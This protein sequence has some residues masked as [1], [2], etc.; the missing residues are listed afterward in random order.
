MFKTDK[1]LKRLYLFRL[2]N[3][4]NLSHPY[5]IGY[6]EN[7]KQGVPYEWTEVNSR[8][9]EGFWG[10]KEMV[11]KITEMLNNDSENEILINKEIMYYEEKFEDKTWWFKMTPTEKW[12]EFNAYQYREKAIEL[13]LL[14]KYTCSMKG[15]GYCPHEQ[16]NGDCDYEHD[17]MNKNLK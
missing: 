6:V 4:K 11:Y 9:C 17:C 12:E 3:H 13:S 16:K 2:Q 15:K 7:P 5:E 14:V 10:D 8:I 1:N